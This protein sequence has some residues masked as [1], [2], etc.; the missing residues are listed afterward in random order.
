MSLHDSSARWA[1]ISFVSLVLASPCL[2]TQ[3][4]MVRCYSGETYSNGGRRNL[5][6]CKIHPL[7]TVRFTLNCETGT[8]ALEVNGVDQGVV[9]SNV[10]RDV[11]PAVCFYGVTKSVRLVELKRTDGHLDSDTSDG[12]NDSSSGDT[13]IVVP[14]PEAEGRSSNTSR[15]QSVEADLVGREGADPANFD[16]HTDSAFHDDGSS[17]EPQ[18]MHMVREELQTRTARRKANREEE[19]RIAE[20]IHAAVDVSPSAGLLASLANLAQWYVPR[21][22]EVCDED[23]RV[24]DKRVDGVDTEPE[25]PTWM[26]GGL[27]STEYGLFGTVRRSIVI[28]PV[29]VLRIIIKPDFR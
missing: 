15:P 18:K 3:M 8:L 26:A 6:T 27:W 9:F 19:K 29:R 13:P 4:W 16:E 21:H 25:W 20:A 17:M 10:P 5:M 23:E 12:E 1:T 14:N 28:L 24:T 2:D 11:H 22:Q 7:D